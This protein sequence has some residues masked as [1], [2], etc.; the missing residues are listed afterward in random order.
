MSMGENIELFGV[1]ELEKCVTI[2]ISEFGAEKHPGQDDAYSWKAFHSY[3][4]AGQ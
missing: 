3:P 1:P 2:L 4:Q